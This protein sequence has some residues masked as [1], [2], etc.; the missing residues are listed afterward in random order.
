[1]QAGSPHHNFIDAA[2]FIAFNTSKQ[3]A[4]RRTH[5]LAPRRIEWAL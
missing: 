1:M 4:F 2:S 3:P 5:D